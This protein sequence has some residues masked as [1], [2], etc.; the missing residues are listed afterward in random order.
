MLLVFSCA[1]I[2]AALSPGTSFSRTNQA[3]TASLGILKVVEYRR[4][5]S[6]VLDVRGLG[7]LERKRS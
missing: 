2:S 5:K 4:K 7:K 1:P 3:S 6:K